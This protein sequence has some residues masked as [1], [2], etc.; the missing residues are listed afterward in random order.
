MNC[1]LGVSTIQLAINNET[2]STDMA[3]SS[4]DIYY[5]DKTS[6]NYLGP[7]PFSKITN[8]YDGMQVIWAEL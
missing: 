1:T 4:Y 5:D 3:A 7:V 8:R 6:G 2:S